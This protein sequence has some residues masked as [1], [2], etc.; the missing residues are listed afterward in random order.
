MEAPHAGLVE[1]LRRTG[2]H[3]P[4]SRGEVL[5]RIEGEGDQVGKV[6]R[7][8]GGADHATAV[9]RGK[10]V[11]SILDHGQAMPACDV[12]D[13][14]HVTW[15][16]V[17]MNRKNGLDAWRAPNGRLDLFGV[18]VEGV[19]LHVAQA[20]ASSLVLDDVDARAE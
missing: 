2:Q 1:Q 15:M 9:E 7:R 4:L 11:G 19:P 10:G 3:P 8:L 18:D 6:E 17:E 16:A 13:R 5:G 14:V 20:R 12:V